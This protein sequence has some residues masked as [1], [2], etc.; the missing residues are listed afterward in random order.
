MKFGKLVIGIV[1]AGTGTLLLAGKLGFLPA[2]AWPWL[3]RY[4]PL[5]LLALGVALLAN[6]LKNVLIGV[7]AAALAIGSFAFGWWWITRYSDEAKNEYRTTIDLAKPQAKAVTFAGRVVGGSMA[8][9][10]DSSAH[11]ALHF[12]VQGITDPEF[13]GHRWVVSKETGILTW[14]AESGVAGTGIVGGSIRLGAPALTSTRVECSSFFSS[15]RIDL[16]DL[17][18]AQCDVGTVGSSVRIDVGAAR[19]PG[20]RV[21]GW[22]S[23]V[24]IHLPEG[25]PTRIECTS[26]LT[27]RS[28]PKDFVEHSSASGKGKATY[29]AGEGPGRP[30][31]IVIDGP[32]M[33][34]RVVRDL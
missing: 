34:V 31:S 18:P 3:L 10:A 1:L 25:C 24:E 32:M 11:G 15:A 5:V 14:P 2:G 13:A 30:V 12:D 17:R 29:W 16:W 33:R 22:L 8:L 26:S 6:A 7:I 23:N 21:H 20:I 27:M 4:W 9:A 28:Y 19:P